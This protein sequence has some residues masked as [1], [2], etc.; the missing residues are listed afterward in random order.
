MA[1]ILVVDDSIFARLKICN[2]LKSLGHETLEAV[3]GRDGLQKALTEQP[4]CICTDLLMPELD[5]IGFLEALREAGLDLPV[6]VLT[7]DI[8]ETKRLQCLELGAADFIHK[9]P[10]AGELSK[11]ME[12]VLNSGRKGAKQC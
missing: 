7:A 6:V 9:P 4:D 3:D 2:I 5:G 1:R 11:V 10:H 8:Q 12:K